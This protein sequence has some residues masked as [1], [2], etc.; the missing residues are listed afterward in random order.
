VKEN[1]L[2]PKSKLKTIKRKEIKC[3]K[4]KKKR[5]KRET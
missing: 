4:K 3:I 1:I 2:N 5:N